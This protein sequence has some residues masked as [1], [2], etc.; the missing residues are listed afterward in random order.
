[1]SLARGGACLSTKAVRSSALLGRKRNKRPSIHRFLHATLPD[2]AGHTP[3]PFDRDKRLDV[4]RD[5][6]AFLG[7][8]AQL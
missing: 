3:F 6:S 2:H 8:H 1:M 7:E 4:I 5:V